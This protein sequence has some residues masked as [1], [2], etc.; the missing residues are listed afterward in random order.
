VLENVASGFERIRVAD[1]AL[2]RVGQQLLFFAEIEIHDLPVL[3][4]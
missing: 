3:K 1:E 2:D 4:I